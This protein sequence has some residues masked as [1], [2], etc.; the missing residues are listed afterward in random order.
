MGRLTINVGV[1]IVVIAA[2]FIVGA[3]EDAY[4]DTCPN[5][6]ARTGPSAALEDCRAYELVTPPDTINNPLFFVSPTAGGFGTPSS[7]ESG[8][9]VLF[10]LRGEA[11]KGT[12]ST[13]TTDTYMTERTGSGWV[14]RLFGPTG[15]QTKAVEPGGTS[16]GYEA[17][18]S[19]ILGGGT[20]PSGRYLVHRDGSLDLLGDGSLADDP[21]PMGR[22]ISPT[23]DHVVFTSEQRLEPE[24]PEG[25][26]CC[27][28]IFWGV[29]GNEPVNA[30]YEWTPG[31]LK[32]LS[33]LPGDQPPPDGS[34]TYYWGTSKD[35]S[36]VIF[37]VGEFFGQNGTMY[38]R[39]DGTTYPIVTVPWAEE[40][41]YMG[42]S[43]SGDKIFYLLDEQVFFGGTSGKLYEYDI[44]TQQS[45][46]ITSA[47]DV[48][49]VNV[50][51]DGSHVYLLSGEQLDGESGSPGGR[52]LYAWDGTKATFVVELASEDVGT[53]FGRTSLIAWP[54]T[55][56]L[57][58][59]SALVGPGSDP[60]RTTPDGSVIAFEAKSNLTAY[61]SEGHS[62]VYRYSALTG[63]LDCVSCNPSGAPPTS[64]A[65]LQ[66]IS[67]LPDEKDAPTMPSADVRNL[68]RD[69]NGVFF[70]TGDRLVTG[71]T[72]GKVDVYGWREG[73]TTLIS[74]GRSGGT[75]EWLYGVS[76]D[77]SNVF[78]TSTDRLVPEKKSD[79]ISIYDARI[80]GG[81]PAASVPV[82]CAV[83]SC[84]GSPSLPGAGPAVGTA[85]ALA[86]GNVKSH[87]RRH[88]CKKLRG[89][90]KKRCLRAHRQKKNNAKNTRRAG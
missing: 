67:T 63:A 70:V 41:V 52:N 61:D 78:F 27:T 60:S 47:A 14:S 50:S 17:G 1:L 69:G 30:V 6:A 3:Y 87:A 49:V 76:P 36:S 16:A 38:V 71:D 22:W 15:E 39:H 20:V 32:V 73:H 4:A 45:R 57:A 59:Q 86:N 82:P 29:A 72:D 31:G 2:T 79:T 10:S 81:F 65:H 40:A 26:G 62:Q 88:P 64:D 66:G 68:T 8:D 48:Q 83:G 7:N 37:N 13:G 35:G 12:A 43:S 9:A 23:G 44:N 84:Q 90:K 33:L 53:D 21:R 89:K 55:V 75:N 11:L 51:E 19:A 54:L 56:S 5:A 85:Q 80:N 24:A 34:T 77:G 18:F 28:F 46:Q 42:S 74:Y 25:V 58:Q